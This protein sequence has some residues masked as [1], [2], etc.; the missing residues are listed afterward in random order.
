[1]PFLDVIKTQMVRLN[2]ILLKPDRIIIITIIT[3]TII[4]IKTYNVNVVNITFSI[5]TIITIHKHR[6]GNKIRDYFS[7]IFQ[8]GIHDT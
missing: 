8:S 7:V 1:M 6:T 5:G 3:F 2:K 4:I